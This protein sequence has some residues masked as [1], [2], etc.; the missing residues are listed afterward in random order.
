MGL[1]SGTSL[2]GLSAG[3]V[4]VKSVSPAFSARFIAGKT[5]SFPKN[6]RGALLKIAESSP[7]Q[8]R[9]FAE[10]SRRLGVFAAQAIKRFVETEKLSPPELVGF[11]G[12]TVYHGGDKSF[13][14]TLQLGDPSP[15]CYEMGVPV[16]SDFRTMDVAAGGQ[17][18]PLVAI[19]DYLKYRSE[20]VG[21]VVLNLGGIANVTLLPAACRLSDVLAFDT[22]P[23]VMAID[24]AYR[25]LVN[26]KKWYD[27]DGGVA[28]SGSVS[29]SLLNSVLNI[30]DYR[31]RP[32]PKTTGR[33][34][35]GKIFVDTVLVEAKRLGV[36]KAD[37]IATL[38]YYTFYM[39]DH[40]LEQ[41]RRRGFEANEIIVG[42]GGSKNPFIMEKLRANCLG[43]KVSV[44]DRYG[45]P[46]DYWESFAF[47]VLSHLSFNGFA[48][49]VPTA[50]GASKPVLLGRINFPAYRTLG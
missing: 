10:L 33:E 36:G 14:A 29:K 26:P 2:D 44:H 47:A 38:S 8:P 22:G 16:V 42:G 49:N 19:V 23:G 48:G 27:K 37:V 5:Y 20:N 9:T 31:H 35:Y 15:I 40:H 46:R 7:T 18:A 41:L 39:V 50:T 13:V 12:Q 25:R 28:F 32:F 11:H 30:D 3:Y 34:R 17:G 21:R 24:A 4:D 43:A 6:I 45:I 1:M